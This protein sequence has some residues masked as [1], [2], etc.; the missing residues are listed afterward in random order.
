MSNTVTIKVTERQAK[1]I[2]LSLAHQAAGIRPWAEMPGEVLAEAA[3]REL[4]DVYSEVAKVL[5]GGK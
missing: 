2:Q 5:G 1:V 3:F 4:R